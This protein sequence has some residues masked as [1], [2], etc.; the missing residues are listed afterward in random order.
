MAIYGK[1]VSKNHRSTKGIVVF[2]KNN[3]GCRPP[4]D[5][6][7][8]AGNF[9]LDFCAG[10]TAKILELY[11]IEGKDTLLLKRFK[12]PYKEIVHVTLTVR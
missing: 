10:S 8:N 9:A 2:I 3:T 6:T 1:L 12:P 11:C 5:T 7:D 4:F